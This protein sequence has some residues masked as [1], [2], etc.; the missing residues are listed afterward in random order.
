[1]ISA[2][3][4]CHISETEIVKNLIEECKLTKEEAE[5]YLKNFQK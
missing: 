2:Y 3:M 4:K 5:S 1:M